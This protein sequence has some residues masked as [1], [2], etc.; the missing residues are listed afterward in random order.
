MPARNI[1]T[2]WALRET[3]MPDDM[4]NI[5]FNLQDLYNIT[6]GSVQTTG[7]QTITGIKIFSSPPVSG[8]A[9]NANNQPF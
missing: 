2:D 9:P 6:S 1:K 4:N 8:N 3:V 5:G 7:N